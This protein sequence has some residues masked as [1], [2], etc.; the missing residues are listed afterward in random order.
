VYLRLGDDFK[1]ASERR[2]WRFWSAEELT[3]CLVPKL[4]R[5]G[6]KQVFVATD[7]FDMLAEF[8]DFLHRQDLTMVVFG[9]STGLTGV[10]VISVE[11]LLCAHSKAFFYTDHATFAL[12]VKAMRAGLG[13]HCPAMMRPPAKTPHG[14]TRDLLALS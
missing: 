14:T 9:P 10:E 6:V 7:R 5:S 3:K 12:N 13:V 1:R 8:E 4:V 11:M 2:G